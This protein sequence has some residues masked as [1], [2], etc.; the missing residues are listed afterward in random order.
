MPE[1]RNIVKAAIDST[2]VVSGAKEMATATDRATREMQQ[3]LERANVVF[4]NFS[5]SFANTSSVKLDSSGVRRGAEEIASATETATQS[6]I[7][8][9]SRIPDVNI[10]LDT[11]AVHQGAAEVT[12]TV[13]EAMQNV[14]DSISRLPPVEI[15]VESAKAS[16]GE[17][18]SKTHDS[19]S[20]IGIELSSLPPADLDVQRAEINAAHLADS[21]SEAISKATFALNSI[22]DAQL[23][24]AVA[25]KDAKEISDAVT[26]AVAEIKTALSSIPDAEVDSSGVKRSAKEISDAIR[27]AEKDVERS[28]ENLPTPTIDTTGVKRSVEELKNLSDIAESG[29]SP[30]LLVEIDTLQAQASIADLADRV[31]GSVADVEAALDRIANKRVN[32]SGVKTGTD[33]ITEASRKA[34]KEIEELLRD[35]DK[36]SKTRV[37]TDKITNEIDDISRSS[38]RAANDVSR[39]TNRTRSVLGT[40]GRA[41]GATFSAAAILQFTKL[42]IQAYARQDEALRQLGARVKATDNAA[43]FS[44]KN[45]AAMATALSQ[46]STASDQAI[47]EMQGILLTFTEIRGP[48]FKA[49]QTAILDLS[50]AMGLSLP[51]AATLLGRALEDPIEGISALS[52]SGVRF[53]KEQAKVIEQLVATGRVADAQNLILAEF[54]RRMGGAAKASTEGAGKIVLMQNAVADAAEEIGRFIVNSSPVDA[55]IREI[56]QQAN[57]LG[58]NTSISEWAK[59]TGQFFKTVL[60]TA[61]AL[62]L[63]V[64][65]LGRDIALLAAIAANLD[66][67]PSFVANKAREIAGFEPGPKT[68]IEVFLEKSAADRAALDKELQQ[69][70][71]DLEGIGAK[72]V[73]AAADRLAKIQADSEGAPS[74]KDRDPPKPGKAGKSAEEKA[75]ED[76]ERL[77]QTLREQIDTLG[78]SEAALL[79]YETAQ[80][81]AGASSEELKSKANDLT[82]ELVELLEAEAKRE[83]A[84]ERQNEL[85]NRAA[86]L[87]DATIEPLDRYNASLREANELLKE[88]IITQQDYVKI[89][90]KAKEDY[91]DAIDEIDGI[92][93]Q[94]F[95][96]VEGIVDDF[97]SSFLDIMTGVTENTKES[98]SDMVDSIIKD[99]VRLTLQRQLIDPIV[100][101]ASDSLTRGLFGGGG[102][103][104]EG[105]STGGNGISIGS[106]IGDFFKNIFGRNSD[107]AA[108]HFASNLGTVAFGGGLASGGPVSPGKT[109]LVGERGPEFFQPNQ[110]GRIL[111]NGEMP[112]SGRSNV[113]V[114]NNFTIQGGAEVSQ[115]S[116][117]QIAARVGQSLNRS[118]ARIR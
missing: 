57:L 107:S 102:S 39:A 118:L 81:T 85:Q 36:L 28:L 88:S 9:V 22:P 101:G 66:D 52:E 74:R 64:V 31:G 21:I 17:L 61:K 112:E 49:A 11:S 99:I 104:G 84:L 93:K 14:V 113:T 25:R 2:G 56:T 92:S 41:L 96:D 30:E 23:D 80:I 91:E 13:D 111:P 117:T 45:L 10:D 58:R 32:T 60:F 72:K 6:V 37:S 38:R 34:E 42:S 59:D 68:S 73:E 86:E 24:T 26:K 15:N 53:T 8:S 70:V 55:I 77:I 67:I 98:W 29:F 12:S 65:Q 35:V 7:D 51:S 40:F 97:G 115:K 103:I 43:G 16:L 48:Q 3:S 78:L 109:F 1:I 105:G 33:Q 75:N 71:A 18:L 100:S 46:L 95:R 114:V 62:S 19:F 47:Q 44:V 89:V 50:T 69:L 27:K 76:L 83:E 94:R 82:E 63:G 108:N 90:E 54:E 20:E 110:S 4:G 116:Q 87:L 106:G 79:R 5:K